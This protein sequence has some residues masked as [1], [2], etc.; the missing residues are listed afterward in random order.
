L[1]LG[2]LHPDSSQLAAMQ[3]L[4]L[5]ATQSG[6]EDHCGAYLWGSVGCGKSMLMDLVVGIH[7]DSVTRLHFHELMV[8]VHRQLHALQMARPRRVAFTKQGLPIYRYGDESTDSS[9]ADDGDRSASRDAGNTPRGPQGD[10]DDAVASEAADAHAKPSSSEELSGGQTSEPLTRVIAQVASRGTLLC[11]DE[12]QVTDVADAMLLRQLFEGLFEAGVRVVF[13]SN[14]PPER[15]YERGLNR[16]YFLPF[17]HMLYERCAII[18]M[19]SGG[20]GGGGHSTHASAVDYRRIPPPAARAHT[21]LPAA[22]LRALAPRPAGAAF[23]GSDADDALMQRWADQQRRSSAADAALGDGV[24]DQHGDV[25]EAASA[26]MGSALAVEFGRTLAVDAR[27]G[28]ACHFSFDELCGRSPG[29]HALGPADYLALAK[30]ASTLYLSGVPVLTTTMRNEAR[31]FVT[32]I[33]ALYEARVG[34]ILAAAA[35]LE[36]I[37]AP[38]LRDGARTRAEAA[39]V[40]A[41]DEGVATPGRA[42]GQ[43]YAIRS[44]PTH[45]QGVEEVKEKPAFEE[46][47]VGGAFRVDG[48]LAAFFT[49]KDEAFMLRRTAS[50]LREMTDGG[51]RSDR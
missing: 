9:D 38:L 29:S 25:G 10:G 17:V 15:L 13:T 49:G 2:H 24:S 51:V 32:L 1:D 33:D 5:F 40:E 18:Q 42:M 45:E 35:P 26:E 46:A 30:A 12:M 37:F 48:E 34:L 39:E 31:R 21:P 23:H 36:E 27:A 47:P 6:A 8:D 19:G 28:G 11:I 4:N 50:R 41:P 22:S 3:A 20:G 16:K 43:S 7:G 14:R 44:M